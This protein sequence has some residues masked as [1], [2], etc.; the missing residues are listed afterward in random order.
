MRWRGRFSSQSQQLESVARDLFTVASILEAASIAGAFPAISFLVAGEQRVIVD[1]P[2]RFLVPS[3]LFIGLTAY[4]GVVSPAVFLSLTK[5]IENK[6]KL[7]SQMRMFFL[8]QLIGSV[9]AVT[10]LVWAFL[11]QLYLTVPANM[12]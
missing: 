8:V 6:R 10:T 12:D 1:Q 7:L 2:Y 4:V 3:F 11:F 9:S 5:S